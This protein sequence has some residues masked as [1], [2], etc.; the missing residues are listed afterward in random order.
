VGVHSQITMWSIDRFNA[1]K[2]NQLLDARLSLKTETHSTAENKNLL[3]IINQDKLQASKMIGTA[4]DGSWVA[5]ANAMGLVYHEY[6]TPES[7][8]IVTIR[9]LRYAIRQLGVTE[10]LAALYFLTGYT[11]DV[12]HAQVMWGASHQSTVEDYVME[13]LKARFSIARSEMKAGHKTCVGQ[14]YSQVYNRKKQKLQMAVL[15]TDT[16]LAVVSNGFKTKTNWRRPKTQYFV[17]KAVAD[18]EGGGTRV[19]SEL[20]SMRYSHITRI[21]IRLTGAAQK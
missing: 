19:V 4:I 8:Q 15:P 17:H 9:D 12:L 16:S 14:L 13:T 5:Y 1:R 2:G 18:D 6:K 21:M 20:V 3:E 11:R 7:R 10:R